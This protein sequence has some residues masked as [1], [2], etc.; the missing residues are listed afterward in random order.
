MDIVSTAVLLFLVMD[1]LGNVPLYVSTLESVKPERR[2][3][4]L[5]R[6][7][8]IAGVALFAFLYLGRPVIGFL[9]ISQY[10]IALAGALILFI[11]ALKMLFPDT[12][13]NYEDELTGEPLIVPLAIPLF[14]GPSALAT[15]LL[16][17]NRT[18]TDMLIL[19]IGL[20]VAWGGSALILLSSTGI[21]KLLGQRGLIAMERLMG[22]VL[23][24]IAVQMFLD[25]LGDYFKA[26]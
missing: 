4:V 21:R 24:A 12:R 7:V 22:M 5:L 26:A 19:S 8:L 17:A 18:D 10:A 20:L 2:F 11:I 13:P 23:V 15:L 1:P 3:R 16:L 14:A 9:G 6:E 25:G